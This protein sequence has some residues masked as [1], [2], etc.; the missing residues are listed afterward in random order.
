MFLVSFITSWLFILGGV[1]GG[2]AYYFNAPTDPDIWMS[3]ICLT[4][5]G[6]VIRYYAGKHFHD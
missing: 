3:L 2:I 5:I 6:G 4:A 1:G